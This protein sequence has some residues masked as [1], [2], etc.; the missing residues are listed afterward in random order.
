MAEGKTV[1]VKQIKSP[2]GYNAKQRET[3]RGLFVKANKWSNV[4]DLYKDEAK[5]CDDDRKIE[6]YWEL[7]NLYGSRL[8]QPGLVVTSL[9]SLEK[10]LEARGDNEALMKV[11]EAQQAQFEK[12]KRWPDLIGRIRRVRH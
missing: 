8:R 2:I 5:H 11:V 6:V 9:A 1:K 3:L 4:A 10:L 7:I 12:M